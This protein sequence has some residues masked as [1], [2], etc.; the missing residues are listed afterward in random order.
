LVITDI[1]LKGKGS[2]LGVLTHLHQRALS[3]GSAGSPGLRPAVVVFTNYASEHMRQRCLSLGA[4]R[5]FDKS[6]EIDALLDYCAGLA[7]AH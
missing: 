3:P 2:G 6:H 7:A 5:V 1:F 4:D